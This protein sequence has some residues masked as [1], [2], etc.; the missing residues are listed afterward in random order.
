MTGDDHA[1]GGTAGRFE[2]YKGFSPENC[3]V[4]DWECVRGTSYIFPNF[5]EVFLSNAQA[6]AFTA[7]G[8]EIFVHVSTGCADWTPTSL[9]TFYFEQIAAL[10]SR[11]P[12]LASG[13]SHRTHCIAWT[14]YTTQATVSLANGVRFD[15]NYYHFGPPGWIGGLPGF[16]TGSG[17]P[18]RFADASGNTINVYQAATQMTDESGQGYPE[19]VDAL[20]DKALGPQGFYGAFTANMHTDFNDLNDPKHSMEGSDAIIASAQDRGVPVVSSK[21]MLEWLDGRNASTFG[22]ISRLADTVSF[23]VSPGTGSRGLQVMLPARLGTK[24]IV[25][26]LL[27][28]APVSYA[29]ET[30]KGV[31]YALFNG[32][33]GTYEAAY[34]VDQTPPQISSLIAQATGPNTAVIT[35]NTSEPANSRVDLGTA[36]N[37]LHSGPADASLVTSHSVSLTGLTPETTYYYRVQSTDSAG[38]SATAPLASD[39]PGI[40]TTLSVPPPPPGAFVDTTTADF[41]AGL[42]GDGLRVSRAE[43]GELVLAPAVKEEFT[44]GALPLGWA[45]CRWQISGA[46]IPDNTIV[47]QN[48]VLVIDGARVDTSAFSL[49]GRAVEFR[50]KFANQ[51]SQH[52]GFGVDFNSSPL[53]AIFSTGA[54]GQ[55]YARTNAGGGDGCGTANV[56]TCT[57][58]GATYLDGFHD[59]RIEWNGSNVVYSID[60]AVKATHTVAIAGS[61]QPIA[62]SDFLL[63]TGSIEV[64]SFAMSAPY[65]NGG[66]FESRIFDAGVAT[67]WGTLSSTNHI[68]ASTS[69]AFSVRVGDTPTPDGA[70]SAFVPVP[71]GSTIGGSSRYLQ[72]RAALGTANPG[73]TPRLDAV[74]IGFGGVAPG[75]DVTPPV[76]SNVTASATS[77][78]TAIVQ[79]STNEPAESYVDYGISGLGSATGSAALVLSHSVTVTGLTPGQAY[80]Y[81]VRSVDAAGNSAT[82]PV[83]GTLTFTT[84][85]L[86]GSPFVETTVAHF[87][88]GTVP[89]QLEVTQVGDGEVRLAGNVGS[90]FS[91]PLPASWSVVQWNS[92]FGGATVN[93]AAGL[94][95]VDGA[96]VDTNAYVFAGRSLEF[97]AKFAGDASQ[98]VGFGVT[99]NDVPWAIFSTPWDRPGR[100]FARSAGSTGAVETE[101]VDTNY[102]GAFHTY[103][104]EWDSTQ[105]RYFINGQLKATHA[106]TIAAPMQPIAASDLDF[107]SGNIVVDSFWLSPSA[108][109]GTFLSRVLDAGGGADWDTLSWTA[110][111][112]ALS[113]LGLSV[114]TGDT[115]TPGGP[116][117]EPLHGNSGVGRRDS[118]HVALHPIPRRAR[119]DG[120]PIACA[121]TRDHRL[122]RRNRD[123][124]SAQR[125]RRRLLDQRGH[126]VG[127]GGA[128]PAGQRHRC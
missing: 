55:L 116:A 40:F 81:R 59:Y 90:D 9:G 41:S 6:A 54:G 44:N 115:P 111:T 127:R 20:L 69:V 78:T 8:F 57:P 108:T 29:L 114:R 28:S 124:Q 26:L 76:I 21:Q 72:Y 47:P 87:S 110:A 15:T 71:Q 13:V 84:P 63:G 102:F 4:A 119:L 27:N 96:R 16:M 103:R 3:S 1:N 74:S 45:P 91:S 80:D 33:A 22:S 97:V 85:G 36:P 82:A 14:D 61:M 95:T 126:G 100:F 50:A 89:A 7:E 79:W 2:Q 104:I 105:I 37:A 122:C 11:Y 65:G 64:D 70:W 52:I 48:G 121:R 19:T 39:P 86:A 17:L 77:T 56:Q 58:L 67:N 99:L 117:C 101:I 30:I 83:A 123:E 32:V 23:T 5:P 98:H 125:D 34:A 53:W 24:T 109:A 60:G 46:C 128:W 18:M 12:S 118:G 62:A 35:W 10:V 120:S 106:I 49:A 68:P 94:M 113:A 107:G 92:G 31:D 75:P 51:P 43:D 38:L 42:L 112:P 88:A 25:Q 73:V 93:Q 66:V